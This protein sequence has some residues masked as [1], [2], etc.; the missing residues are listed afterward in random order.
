MWTMSAELAILLARAMLWLE[1]VNAFIFGDL[2]PAS[3]AGA[4][5]LLTMRDDSCPTR[6][7]LVTDDGPQIPRPTQSQS[8]SASPGPTEAPQALASGGLTTGSPQTKRDYAA[9]GGTVAMVTV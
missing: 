3:G 4:R 6:W 7:L 8:P 2:R 9:H 5:R 1:N